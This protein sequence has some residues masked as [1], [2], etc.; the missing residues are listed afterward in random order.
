[1]S[2]ASEIERIKTNIANAYA[3]CGE[4]GAILPTILNSD[5][6]ANCILSITGGGEPVEPTSGYVTNGLLIHFSGE[7]N[8][9]D[10][11]WVD[12]VTGYKFESL[13]SGTKM[14]TYDAFN[15]LYQQTDKGGL[16]SNFTLP[17]GTNYTF[18]VVARDL[19]NSTNSNSSYYSTIVGCQMENWRQTDGGVHLYRLDGSKGIQ[20]GETKNG[21]AIMDINTFVDNALDTLTQVPGQAIYRNGEWVMDIGENPYERYVG[22]FSHYEGGNANYYRGRGKIHAVRVYNRQ[23]TAE[24]V[25]QNHAEDIRI[26]GA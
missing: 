22:L 8:Y 13:G 9:V 24:E 18:E 21:L 1:M 10:N 20:F 17:A 11:A 26:Y 7:D 3:V 19:K 14:P 5:N 23:L 15:R 2:I 6:L 4:K 16:K 25:A 12:R